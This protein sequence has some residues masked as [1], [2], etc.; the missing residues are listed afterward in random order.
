MK[1]LSNTK[2]YLAEYTQFLESRLKNQG[3]HLVTTNLEYRVIEEE[4]YSAKNWNP[5]IMWQG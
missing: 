1:I 3:S 4:P 5:E 2:N